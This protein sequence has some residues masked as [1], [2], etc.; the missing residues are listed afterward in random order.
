LFLGSKVLEELRILLRLATPNGL[1]PKA[2]PRR[3]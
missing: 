2:T 1:N 3:S